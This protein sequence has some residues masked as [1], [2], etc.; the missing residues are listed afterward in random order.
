M[1]MKEDRKYINTN[2]NGGGCGYETPDD[3]EQ[4]YLKNYH[5]YDED[6]I[7]IRFLTHYI[8]EGK[9]N[10]LDQ[11]LDE[12]RQKS[13]YTII[14][15]EDL[16]DEEIEYIKFLNKSYNYIRRRKLSKQEKVDEDGMIKMEEHEAFMHYLEHFDPEPK[17]DKEAALKDVVCE[18]WD[19]LDKIDS[20]ADV[21]I[22]GT[23]TDEKF[24]KIEE[25]TKRRH[26]LVTTDGYDLFF[27]GERINKIPPT[28]RY[29]KP[30]DKGKSVKDIP[31]NI[32]KDGDVSW[33]D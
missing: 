10:D 9:I 22:D 6:S 23:K 20:Y 14:G 21:C 19:I 12:I 8:E 7:G 24:K 3:P 31:K 17:I 15:S 13:T 32:P 29:I 28:G 33:D 11:I 2:Y 5:P 27:M 16:T 18:L 25:L 4:N 1:A 30:L 26:D